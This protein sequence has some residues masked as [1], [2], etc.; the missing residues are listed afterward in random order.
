M[1][2]Q[3]NGSL[4]I[5]V[6]ESITIVKEIAKSTKLCKSEVRSMLHC[7]SKLNQPSQDQRSNNN[8]MTGKKS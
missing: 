1:E 4:A 6:S 5:V 8:D 2:W 7:N 3:N